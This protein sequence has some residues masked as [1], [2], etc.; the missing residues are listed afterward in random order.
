MPDGTVKQINP[1][2]GTEV[3]AVAGRRVKPIT[4]ETA[5]EPQKLEKHTPEDYCSF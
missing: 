5:R 3:W 2:T 1:F 4:N